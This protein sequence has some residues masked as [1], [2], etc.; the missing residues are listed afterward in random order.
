LARHA[1]ACDGVIEALE[2]EH[3][4]GRSLQW[5]PE[6]AIDDHAQ[7]RIFHALV[8]AARAEDILVKKTFQL[9]ATAETLTELYCH[10]YHRIT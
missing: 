7:Q 6:L 1:H 3:H 8:E 2:H 5:H 10:Y 9:F 4:P